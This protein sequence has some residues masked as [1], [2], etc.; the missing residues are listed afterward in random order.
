LEVEKPV[1]AQAAIEQREIYY[2]GR[3][4]GVGFRYTVRRVATRFAVTGFVKNLRDGRVQLVA[5]GASD[6]V[7]RFVEAVEAEM[8]Y[9]ISDAHVKIGP[10][11]GQFSTFDIRF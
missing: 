10:A 4:Q 3:V 8:G 7:Q 6:Q 2:S 11:T 9:Y 1:S 5:E